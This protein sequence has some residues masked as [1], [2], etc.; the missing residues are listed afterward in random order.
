MYCYVIFF[1]HIVRLSDSSEPEGT[2]HAGKII[3]FSA[4]GSGA[5]GFPRPWICYTDDTSNV[6]WQFPNGSK[7]KTVSSAPYLATDTRLFSRFID[8]HG[9]ALYR[10]PDYNS[11]EGEYCCVRTTTNERKCVTFSECN[12]PEITFL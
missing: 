8:H 10:G 4:V 6:E 11:S 5:S 3:T 2:D 9:I 1:I 12:T 7:I